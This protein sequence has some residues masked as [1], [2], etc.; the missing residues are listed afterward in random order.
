MVEEFADCLLTGAEPR[1]DAREA[2]ANMAAIEALY[3]SARAGGRPEAV[4]RV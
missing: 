3:R 1:Y 2:A 4:A